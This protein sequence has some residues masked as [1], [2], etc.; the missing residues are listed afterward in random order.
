MKA[1]LLKAVSQQGKAVQILFETSDDEMMDLTFGEMAMLQ[2]KP[3]DLYFHLRLSDDRRPQTEPPFQHSPYGD[4]KTPRRSIAG[5]ACDAI[6]R[7]LT[8]DE[9]AAVEQCRKRKEI[10]HEVDN[11]L[12]DMDD[13]IKLQ[14][15]ARRCLY[16]A[17]HHLPDSS[18]FITE[19]CSRGRLD[20]EVADAIEQLFGE[21]AESGEIDDTT[22]ICYV[23]EQKAHLQVGNDDITGDDLIG[24]ARDVLEVP[25]CAETAEAREARMAEIMAEVAAVADPQPEVDMD[26][27][28]AENALYDALMSHPK[29]T[30]WWGDLVKCGASDASI[31]DCLEDAFAGGLTQ[32]SHGGWWAGLSNGAFFVLNEDTEPWTGDELISTVR[33]ILNIPSPKEE[34]YSDEELQSQPPYEDKETSPSEMGESTNL[35]ADS[36]GIPDSDRTDRDVPES[37]TIDSDNPPVVQYRDDTGRLFFVGQGLGS[38]DDPWFTLYR[39]PGKGSHRARSSKLPT[40]P[41]QAEA[42]TDLDAYAREKGWLAEPVEDEPAQPATNGGF[43]PGMVITRNNPKAETFLLIID[44]MTSEGNFLVQDRNSRGEKAADAL[45]QFYR[46]VRNGEL[47]RRADAS[48]LYRLYAKGNTAEL[49]YPDNPDA[50]PVSVPRGQLVNYA[51]VVAAKVAQQINDTQAAA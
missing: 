14:G 15:I 48:Q 46:V 43:A 31:S 38:G 23:T 39:D 34:P 24:L 35:P 25:H 12:N 5:E 47:I 22:W 30:D 36:P 51:T 19:L 50:M 33:A 13:V 40:R 37:G 7:A 21:E 11:L 3:V 10:Q 28:Q 9:K 41:K 8:D 45:A 44:E 20:I 32:G 17:I 4:D 18:A 1:T 42:Q 49:W 26:R 27:A 2:E 29:A 16:A 6:D